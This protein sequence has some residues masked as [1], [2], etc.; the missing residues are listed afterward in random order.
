MIV[1][2]F[3]GTSV[4]NEEAIGRVVSIVRGRLAEKPVVVV[5]ALSKVTRLLV[6][7]AEDAENGNA[8]SVRTSLAQLRKRHYDVCDAMLGGELLEQ[9]KDK[10]DD[11]CKQLGT[12]VEGVCQIGELSPRS[13]A[14]IMATGELLSSTIVSAAM[15]AAGLRCRWVD[16]RRLIITDDNYLNARPD[17]GVSAANICRIIPRE[18]KGA[19]VV[20]TQGF[21]SSTTEGGPSVLGFEGSDYSAA[22]IGM[23]LDAD[24]VEIWTDVDG[25]RTSDPRVVSPTAKIGRVSYEEAAQMA[26]LGARVLHPM[27]IGPARGRNIPIMVLNTM[28]PACEGSTVAMY[29]GKTGGP[30]AVAF[31][32]DIDYVEISAPDNTNSVE[33]ISDVFSILKENK[34]EISLISHSVG[35]LSFTLESGQPGLASAVRTLSARYTLVHYRDKS[36]LSVVGRELEVCKGISDDIKACGKVYMM[37]QGASMMDVSAVVDRDSLDKMVNELHKILFNG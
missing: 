9:T 4:Q 8:D 24:R 34:L 27:T 18:S 37:S 28:N 10:V 2:K 30:K 13:K 20:L 36:Q 3:G 6:K 33:M 21:I 15:N 25:I 31:L 26:Y 1:M 29:D 32:C 7:M 5:S 14:R 17:L 16:A 23:A 12:F 22:I 35:R 19:D 11:F